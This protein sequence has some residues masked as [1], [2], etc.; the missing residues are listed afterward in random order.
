MKNGINK[1]TLVGT[2]G[3]TPRISEKDGEPFAANFSLI[4]NETYRDK[5]GEE[6][7]KS[8]WHR[9]VAWND[10]SK[11]VKNHLIKGDGLYLEGKIATNSWTD[12]EGNMHFSNE[13]VCDSLLF[14]S[15]KTDPEVL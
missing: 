13:I 14:L 12:K 4:T 5:D 11:I 8:Q 7:V 2:V 10:L 15:P 9:I 3:E 6:V 1:V